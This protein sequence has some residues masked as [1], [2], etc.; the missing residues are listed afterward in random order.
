LGKNC[1]YESG[2]SG[3]AKPASWL[4]TSAPAMIKK[5]VAQATSIANRFNPRLIDIADCRLQIADLVMFDM[6]QL[7]VAHAGV[8]LGVNKSH[9]YQTI[10]NLQSEI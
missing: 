6:L 2:Q 5:N 10:L 3:A 8:M 7:V 4:V 1:P 9:T